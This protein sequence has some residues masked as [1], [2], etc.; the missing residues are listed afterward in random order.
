MNTALPESAELAALFAP[1]RQAR[2][3]LLAVSG[4]P[5]SMAL[6]RLAALW[7]DSGAAPPLQVATVEDHICNIY[8]SRREGGL[9]AQCFRQCG[10]LFKPR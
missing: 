9:V 10:T 8:L 5:D 2:A 7:R 3:A 6:L 4:G 1:A